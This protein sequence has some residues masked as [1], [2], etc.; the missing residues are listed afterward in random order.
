MSQRAHKIEL[1]V[2]DAPNAWTLSEI[3]ES[4]ACVEFIDVFGSAREARTATKR[5]AR[6]RKLPIVVREAHPAFF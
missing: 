3:D 2:S 6:E 1:D 5:A 4:G